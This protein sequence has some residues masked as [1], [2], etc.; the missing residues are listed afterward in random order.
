MILTEQ[1]VTEANA[2][3]HYDTTGPEIWR[4]TEGDV[5]IVVV[6]TGT[7]GTVTGTGE[8]LRETLIL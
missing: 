1:F 2:R 7:G 8:E 4:D 5:D 6:G 3:I